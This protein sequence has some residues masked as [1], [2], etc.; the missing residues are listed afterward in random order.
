MAGLGT[1]VVACSESWKRNGAV[2]VPGS[3]A[4]ARSGVREKVQFVLL[5]IKW[6]KTLLRY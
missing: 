4:C 6:G 1:P 5:K 3:G 2:L